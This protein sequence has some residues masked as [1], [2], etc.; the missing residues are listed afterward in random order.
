MFLQHVRAQLQP[1]R[2][3]SLVFSLTPLLFCA[4]SR[5]SEEPILLSLPANDK[6][7]NPDSHAWWSYM[8]TGAVK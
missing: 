3:E 8:L 6:T 2:P 5:L 1:L 4:A 7:R